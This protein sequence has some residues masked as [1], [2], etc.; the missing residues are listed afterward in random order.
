MTS[1]R[2]LRAGQASAFLAI[3][4]VAI[5]VNSAAAVTFNF[6]S[7]TYVAGPL[8]GQDGWI[9]NTYYGDPNGAVTV[10][11]TAPLGGAQSISYVEATAGGLADVGRLG[12]IAV[13]DI[14]GTDVTLSYTIKGTT[15]VSGPNGGVFIGNGAPFGASPIFA[16]LNGGVVEVG[17]AGAFVPVNAFFFSPGETIKMTYEIDFGLGSM[18][19]ILE[20]LVGGEI[21]SQ[22]YPFFAGYGAPTGPNGEYNIDLGIFFR[23]GNVTVDDITLTAGV[24][25]IQTN[26][27]WTAN[28]TGNW[29]LTT[30]W[31]PTGIPG[32]I[33]GRQNVLLGS[34]ITAA[35]TIYNNEARTLNTLTISN[36]NS[37]IVAGTGTLGFQADASGPTTIAP[38]INVTSGAHQIQLAVELFNDTSV[39][40]A[41]GASLDFNNVVDLNGHMLTTSGT[42]RFNHSTIGGGAVMSLGSLEAEGVASFGGD[43][44]SKGAML[45]SADESGNS[46]YQVAGDA[47]LSGILDVVWNASSLPAGQMTI[48]TAGGTLDASG[49][50][51]APEDAKSFALGTDGNN[52][53]LTFLGVAVPEPTT[54]GLLGFAMTGLTL[55]RRRRVQVR[56]V[57]CVVVVAATAGTVGQ[58]LAVNY[59][60][61]NPPYTSGNI[62]G[63]QNWTTPAYVLADPFFGGVL[64]GTAA[65]S[66]VNPIGGSQSLLYSQTVDPPSAGNTGAAD[67][68]RANAVFAKKDGTPANDLT[69][70]F[71]IR[72]DANS[73]G[74]GS[75]GFFLGRFGA[76]PIFVLITDASSSAGTGS[77]L[78]GDNAA[79]STSTYVAN[80]VYEYTF[81]VDVDSAT[82]EVTS[83]NIT[84]GTPA[85]T[86]TGSGPNGRFVFLGGGYGS[87]G[88]DQTYTFDTTVLLRSGEARIDNITAI[89]ADYTEALWGGGSGSWATNASWIPNIAPNVATGNA[90]IA[91]FGS[92]ITSPQTVVTGATQTVNGLRFDNA[93]KYA[94]SG[95]GAV[96][97][98]ANTVGGTVNPT[99][100]VLSGSHEVQTRL[101]VLDNTTITVAAGAQ[102]D[103]NN[104]VELG[105]KTLATAGAVNLNYGVTGGGSITNTGVLG[106]A[107]TTPIAANLTSTGTLAFDLG[108]ANTDFFN[109]TGNATLSG[110]VDI[111]LEPGFVPSGSYTLLTVS[112]TL[113]TAGLALTPADAS[114]FSLGVSGKSLVLTVGGSTPIPGDF[115]NNGAVDGA[116]LTKWKTDFGPGAGSDANGD[117]RT[118]GADFLIW[119][120]NFGR[121]SAVPT[122]AA[123]PEPTSLALGCSFACLG[124]VV[125]RRRR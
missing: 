69:A 99:I 125:S 114:Q 7:P 83:R 29:N 67:V 36:T 63:Q 9:K 107:G 48:L 19:L 78:I 47:V 40:A 16:R 45:V 112:G 105:G 21:A 86:L 106:T 24:G 22:V 6:E 122:S 50:A 74:S 1:S 31:T 27:E 5:A 54:A 2:L 43:L 12:A 92:R 104:A 23:G 62:V 108:L 55:F 82:Y 116:D 88:D 66:T 28:A 32:T 10:S 13:Q 20:N 79:F 110:L 124:W 8:V 35:R 102:I 121:T 18:N 89:G 75:A 98:K 73:V 81:G 101:S 71:Q 30:N 84:A 93:N 51:L 4:C 111:T 95:P 65:V 33:A 77:V 41:A 115:N 80:S 34:A 17:S 15:G 49:L 59:N 61:E 87:D 11:S 64:N 57:A 96:A 97:L 118:D 52:L 39:T 44:T 26:F 94:I 100:N 119:Q 38:K 91:V 42:V 3:A 58:A 72:T 56:Q 53:T 25:P 70:S 60:F 14:Q 68:S 117:G 123:V 46:F 109:I 76:S 120:R 113:N 37:Y 103:F 85:Q 90:P